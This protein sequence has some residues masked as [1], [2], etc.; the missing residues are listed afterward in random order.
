MRRNLFRCVYIA[1]LVLIL[2]LSLRGVGW[3]SLEED[4]EARYSVF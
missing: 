3:K 1:C 2:S 4:T